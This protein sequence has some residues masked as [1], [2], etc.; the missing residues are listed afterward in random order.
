MSAQ[1]LTLPYIFQEVLAGY[2]VPAY[3]LVINSRTGKPRGYHHLGFDLFSYDDPVAT[4]RGKVRASGAGTVLGVGLDGGVGNCVVIQYD[5]AQLADGRTMPLIARYFHLERWLCQKGQRVTADTIIGI[6]GM[7]GTT[8][9][10]LHLEFDKDTLWPFYS[11]QVAGSNF[12]K[13]GGY[14]IDSTI[15][16]ALVFWRRP[17][18]TVKP[19]RYGTGWNGPNDTKLSE[20]QPSTGTSTTELIR[21]LTEAEAR[22]AAAEAEV[23]R[24]TAIAN[25]YNRA[26]AIFME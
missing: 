14:A 20:L 8:G 3:P 17:G 12:I 15:D 19:S 24:L 7:T 5:T 1:R 16:P 25:K 26:K 4:A 11:K 9:T 21:R 22:A 10:H 13:N 18:D 2:K 6:E 23:T